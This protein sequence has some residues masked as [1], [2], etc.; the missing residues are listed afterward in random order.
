MGFGLPAAMGAQMGCPDQLVCCM[1]GDGSVQMNMQELATCAEHGIPIKVFIMNNGYLGMVRQWQELFWDGRYSHVDMGRHPDFVKLAEAHGLLGLRV[2]QREQI[3]G[4]YAAAQADPGTVVV[5][6]RVEQEDSV[7][8]MVAAGA[9]LADM[10]R[11]PN[12]LVETGE[13][14]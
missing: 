4:V 5:D 8:P 3:P 1:A 13:D 10:I 6:F 2:T 12:A 11:R 9:D 7:Y 14:P